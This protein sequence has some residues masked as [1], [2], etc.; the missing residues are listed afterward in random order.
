MTGREADPQK[1]FRQIEACEELARRY[2]KARKGPAGQAAGK[3][4]LIRRGIRLAKKAVKQ[5]RRRRQPLPEGSLA[6]DMQKAADRKHLYIR[7]D[8][9]VVYTALY[10]AY[11]RLREPLLTPENIDYFVLTD[12]PVP[13][14]AV[15]K[16]CP[17][18][19]LMPAEI[20]RDPVLANRWCKMH[21]HVLFPDYSYSIYVDA[22]IWILSDMTPVTAGLDRFPVAMFAH[23][24]RDCVYEEVQ[25]CIDQHKADPETLRAHETVLRAHGVPEHGGLFEASVIGRKHGDPRCVSLM[26]AWWEAFLAGSRRDQISLADTLHQAG[27]PPQTVGTLGRNLTQCDL[28]LQM[29]HEAAGPNPALRRPSGAHP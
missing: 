7:P 1:A 25:A 15:W 2:R 18:E 26:D 21:P 8:R 24:K 19:V 12:Q 29:G 22:N 20:R 9:I 27:I 3:K 4:G 28:F 14:D 6:L 23:K 13:P 5:I 17:R 16:L 10:G 11:D